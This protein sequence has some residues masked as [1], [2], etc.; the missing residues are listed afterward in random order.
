MVKLKFKLCMNKILIEE[1]YF[2]QLELVEGERF[3]NE[4]ESY[5]SLKSLFLCI[6]AFVSKQH[7]S[8]YFVQHDNV[9]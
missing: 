2:R 5:M 8:L 4:S 1:L 9:F 3:S 6:R 7:L